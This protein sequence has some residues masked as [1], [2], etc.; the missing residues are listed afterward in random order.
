MQPALPQL[1]VN[2]IPKSRPWS[3]EEDRL[4]SELVHSYGGRGWKAISQHFAHRSDLQC[5]HR[6]QKVLNP[7]LVKGPWTAE[8]DEKIAKLVDEYGPKQ[9]SRIASKLPGR[10]GKQCRERWHNHLNPA[11]KRDCWTAQEDILL[12]Q[13]HGDC[14]NRWADI[15]KRLP[16]RTDNSIKNHWNSTLKRK[17]GIVKKELEQSGAKSLDSDPVST[18]IR[19]LCTPANEAPSTPAKTQAQPTLVTPEKTRTVLYYA[20]PDYTFLQPDFAI[21]SQQIMA[22]LETLAG[23]KSIVE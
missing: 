23:E 14:G 18:Y 9:W 12:L 13:A 6:W 8:E 19:H 4:L 1:P 16:G 10:I 22:S 3:P 15:A 17:I 2:A 5:L 21:T 11:I 20:Y 7:E